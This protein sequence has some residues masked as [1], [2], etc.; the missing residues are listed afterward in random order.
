MEKFDNDRTKDAWSARAAHRL[1]RRSFVAG[2]GAMGALAALGSFG[3]AGCASK[4]GNRVRRFDGT[5][6][7][8]PMI[9]FDAVIVGTGGAGLSAAIAAYDK[10]LSTSCCWRRWA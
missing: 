1:T 5:D 3:L 2:A 9:R 4:G 8:K 6:R 7:R 10:G